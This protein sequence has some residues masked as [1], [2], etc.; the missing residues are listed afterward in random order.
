M[1]RILIDSPLHA[2]R[3]LGSWTSKKEASVIFLLSKVPKSSSA[4][5]SQVMVSRNHARPVGLAWES[6]G[7]TLFHLGVTGNG[8]LLCLR[9]LGPSRC[10]VYIIL[11]AVTKIAPGLQVS[12]LGPSYHVAFLRHVPV[13]GA[14]AFVEGYYVLDT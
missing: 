2:T 1:G 13:R 7:S 14:C 12:D 6:G 11:K 10:N 5:F 8:P 3:F 4:A 9:R